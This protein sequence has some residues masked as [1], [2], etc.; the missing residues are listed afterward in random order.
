[1][2]S[3]LSRKFAG[4]SPLGLAGAA[5]LDVGTWSAGAALAFPRP[6]R[7]VRAPRRNLSKICGGERTRT[8]PSPRFTRV[9]SF[10][11]SET[12]QRIRQKRGAP[13]QLRLPEA[14][15]LSCCA[16]RHWEAPAHGAALFLR[17]RS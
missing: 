4:D 15:L 14:E 7:R 16:R 10:S 5:A 13:T 17:T 9:S 3:R 8:Q 12:G 2:Q 1:M 6:V 11:L